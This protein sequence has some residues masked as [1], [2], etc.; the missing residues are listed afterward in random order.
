M[1]TL[2]LDTSSVNS[3]LAIFESGSLVTSVDHHSHKLQTGF[4]KLIEETLETYKI[5]AAE[6]TRVITGIGP[7]S[8]TGVR[9]GV[10]FAKTFCQVT[11]AELIPVE[12]YYLTI[13]EF[14]PGTLYIPIIPS[15]RAECYSTVFSVS[16]DGRIDFH[17]PVCD[18]KPSRIHNWIR[19][20]DSGSSTV[21]Y[22]EG[23]VMLDKEDTFEHPKLEI[24]DPEDSMPKAEYALRLLENY[25]KNFKHVDPL[26]LKP[27]YVRPSPAE[28]KE[29][30]EEH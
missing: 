1:Y 11:G 10:S 14:K 20:L 6:I 26:A 19:D 8:F 30:S 18:G 25:G 15:T 12:S 4:F 9:I 7:G 28:M 29:R 16:E 3:S 27:L 17:H 21:I 23:V 5:N 2:A 13:L 24:I 22:G